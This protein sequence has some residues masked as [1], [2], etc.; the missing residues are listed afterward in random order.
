MIKKYF[1][2][3]LKEEDGATAVIMAFVMVIILSICALVIDLGMVYVKRASLQSAVDSAALAAAY[4]LPDTAVASATADEYIV[5]NG[6]SA[7]DVTI[8]FE[9]DNNVVRVKGTKRIETSFAK[10]FSVN[11]V[12]V[13]VSACAKKE[14]KPKEEALKYLLFTGSQTST[15]SLGGTFEIYGSVHSNGSLSV[16]PAYGYI[17]GSAEA[18]KSYYVNPYTTTVGKKILNAPV[19]DMPDFT[20][21]VDEV[22]PDY[23]ETQLNSSDV[24]G[25]LKQYFTGNTKINGDLKLSNQAVISGNLYV[26]G[27]LTIGGGAPA[28]VL[29]GNIY[30]TGTI[31]FTNTFS[32]HGCVFAYG[33]ISFQGGAAQFATDSPICIYSQT[34]NITLTTGNSEVHGM[35][36]APL[37]TVTVQGDTTTFYGSIIC[38]Q[39]N[40][41]PSALKMYNMDVELP[42]QT[43]TI[44][45]RLVE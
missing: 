14:I 32:G 39:L 3:L 33:S 17:E 26:D 24:N 1:S 10:I 18:C 27:N 23:Y 21:E 11:Y 7:E 45:T 15:M 22:L 36:Y 44:V 9:N 41:I 2:R 4:Q 29:D 19:I 12:D 43:S 40:G 6:F 30:A 31:T 28:C 42:F 5:K 34:G 20:S 37:G 25:R 38:N 8:T 35:I 13:D 16:S